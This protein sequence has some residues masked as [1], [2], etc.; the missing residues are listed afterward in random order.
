MNVWW[1]VFFLNK[2]TN[3]HRRDLMRGCCAQSSVTL[4]KTQGWQRW[5][6][7]ALQLQLKR[8]LLQPLEFFLLPLALQQATLPHGLAG[9]LLFVELPRCLEYL[10]LQCQ[11]GVHQAQLG[12][13]PKETSL[14]FPPCS[15]HQLDLIRG[16]MNALLYLCSL[17]D[18]LVVQFKRSPNASVNLW[19]LLPRQERVVIRQPARQLLNIT[20]IS[21]IKIV[22]SNIF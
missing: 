2:Q 13:L 18:T 3:K 7:A 5:R 1:S 11:L 15:K 9:M 8:R 16:P 4:C 10:H 17:R 21:V 14:N 22:N 12:V 20:E 19:R 6:P